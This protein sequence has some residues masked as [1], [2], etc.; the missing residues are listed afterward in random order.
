MK[1]TERKLNFKA[2]NYQIPWQYARHNTTY[3]PQT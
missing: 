2:I 1:R 3:I